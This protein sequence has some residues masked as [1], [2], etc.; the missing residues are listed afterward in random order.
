MSIT[1]KQINEDTIPWD[2]GSWAVK[3]YLER[4]YTRRGAIAILNRL[5]GV[6][7]D[8][9][10]QSV[11]DDVIQLFKNERSSSPSLSTPTYQPKPFSLGV[12]NDYIRPYKPTPQLDR[13]FSSGSR[14]NDQD[15]RETTEAV[16]GVRDDWH[17]FSSNHPLLSK[18][19]GGVLL[20]G[21]AMAGT[22]AVATGQPVRNDIFGGTTT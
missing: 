13:I 9:A 21:A 7:K 2:Q 1:H 3:S 10:K 12:S 6:I 18:V 20:G 8:P 4:T 22:Y 14:L 11:R 15:R 5:H 17:T 19:V 16:Q